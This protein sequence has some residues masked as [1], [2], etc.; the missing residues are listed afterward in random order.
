MRI[1][2]SFHIEWLGGPDAFGVVL[3]WSLYLSFFCFH[4][5]KYKSVISFLEMRA[6]LDKLLVK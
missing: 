2:W 4:L 1:A 6:Q 3:G 5:A